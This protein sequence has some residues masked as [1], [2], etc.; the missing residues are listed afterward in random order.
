[1]VYILY[2]TTNLVSKK[3]YIGI[4]KQK[5][6]IDPSN[7][8]GYFGSGKILLQAIKKYGKKNFARETLFV[9]NTIEEAKEQEFK[10]VNKLF[11]MD[12]NTY[13]LTIGGGVPPCDPLRWKGRKHKQETLLKISA[14]RKNKGSGKNH[15]TKNPEN[16]ESLNKFRII[17]S[18]NAK[19]RNKN[20]KP[21]LGHVV[22]EEL[23][24]RFSEKNKSLKWYKN[25][26]N[27]T[28]IFSRSCPE[29][30]IPGRLFN[31]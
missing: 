22:S 20:L 7:F 24:K 8:D 11:L 31:K 16:E 25:L 29:G 14:N 21:A 28:C 10:I 4:H 9:F 6:G 19:A 12:E 5:N 18:I 17:N 26:V 30:F 1:M 2:K 23:K 27:N 15:W 3:F 13:N